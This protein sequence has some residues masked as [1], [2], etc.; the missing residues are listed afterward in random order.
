[1]TIGY[2]H[3]CPTLLDNVFG[4]NPSEV[5]IHVQRITLD[6]I[7]TSEDEVTTW[8]VNQFHQKDQLLSGFLSQGHFPHQGREGELSTLKCLVNFGTVLFLTGICTYFTFLSIWLKIYVSLVCLY[9]TFATY[10]NIR[11]LPIS[12]LRAVFKGKSS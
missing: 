6:K 12:D 2:K 4:L 1:M 8:L 3:S 10:F 7:P 5:H 9:L 11:P